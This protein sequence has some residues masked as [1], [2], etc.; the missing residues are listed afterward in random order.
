MNEDQKK[1]NHKLFSLCGDENNA[2][3]ILQII[4]QGANVNFENYMG[5]TPLMASLNSKNTTIGELLLKNGANINYVSKIT[6]NNVLDHLLIRY[7]PRK[8][9]FFSFLIKEG[10]FLDKKNTSSRSSSLINAILS[11]NKTGV[12][13]LLQN[14][15][16]VNTY[17]EKLH[18]NAIMAACDFNYN[19]HLH[20]TRMNILKI[21]L[22]YEPDLEH[23]NE[24]TKTAL[25]I[26]CE[27]RN[28]DVFIL[29]LQHGADPKSVL[30]SK[31]W[32]SERTKTKEM[33]EM[34]EIAEVFYQKQQLNIQNPQKSKLKML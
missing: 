30:F 16:D 7:T 5:Q 8:E 11:N 25:Q 33:L 14:G 24:N 29:L 3:E 32:Q 10:I 19:P 2:T 26:A 34:V 22:N 9:L 31:K 4:K 28:K 13:I 27:R 21:I 6:G 23:K 18:L 12:D 20:D 15:S 17:S 1:L